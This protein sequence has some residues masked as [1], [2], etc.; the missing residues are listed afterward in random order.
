MVQD[1]LVVTDLQLHVIADF[2]L[3]LQFLQ[4]P[5][6]IQEQLK[7]RLQV[8]LV[9]GRRGDVDF[10]LGEDGV[11][12]VH[13]LVQEDSQRVSVKYRVFDV[14]R[15]LEIFV[16]EIGDVSPVDKHILESVVDG[17]EL[18]Y[19]GDATFDVDVADV[20]HVEGPHSARMDELEGLDDRVEEELNLALL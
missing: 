14:R 11:L 16:I 17:N 19:L 12:S 10:A 7:S 9:S 4:A 6:H 18:A 13:Q 15:S 5:T 20:E 8:F 3:L 2:H 1:L